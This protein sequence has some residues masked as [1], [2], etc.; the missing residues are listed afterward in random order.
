[1]ATNKYDMAYIDAMDGHTFENFVAAL[2][3][4]LG[5][6]NVEVTRGSGDQG[7]DVLADKEGVRYAVQCKCY[8]SDLGNTPVQEV[9]TGKVIYHCHVGVVV[10]NRYFTSG[11]KEAAKA[12]G[13]LLWDRT[14]L[15]ELV[16]Q[17]ESMAQSLSNEDALLRRG[18]MALEDEEWRK[19]DGFFEQ[20]INLN[21]ECGDAYLGKVL[22][23][24]QVSSL[25]ELRE[26]TIRLDTYKDFSR[27]LQFSSGNKL[28]VLR[29]VN[30]LLQKRW[31]EEECRRKD[32][33]ERQRKEEKA[34]IEVGQARQ[35]AER[36]RKEEEIQIAAEEKE[37]WIA[38][39]APF[40]KLL[41][42]RS[43]L[44][45]GEN[46]TVG[47]KADGIMITTGFCQEFNWKDIEAVAIGAFYTVGLKTDGTVVRVRTNGIKTKSFNKYD[48]DTQKDVSGWTSIIAIA[49]G[50]DHVAG[51]KSD[52]TVVAV[53]SNLYCQC[54]VSS[55]KNILAVATGWNYTVGLNF[56]GTIVIEGTLLGRKNA[57][58]WTSIVAIA[59][60]SHHA[61]GL[62]SDGTVVAVGNNKSGECNVSDWKD[63]VAVA[64]GGDHTVGLK[65]DGTVLAVGYN[66]NGECDVSSWKDIVA[67]AAGYS[68]TV[69]LKA[70]GTV[71]AVGYN[72]N[73]Q[74]NVSDWK[75][76]NS[77]ETLEQG[78]AD[79]KARVEEQQRQEK[80]HKQ[81]EEERQQQ[82]AIKQ[83]RVILEQEKSS[84]QTEFASLR[85]LFTGKKRREIEAKL[86]EIERRLSNL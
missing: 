16:I 41:Q 72:G 58:S 85:G 73:G 60:G 67:I 34:W 46:H 31:Q 29:E 61:V 48:F 62:K 83:R 27:A 55:W 43:P 1:M 21:A 80:E 56:D 40:R 11:A 7:V 77:I 13:V 38:R 24:V 39:M 6:Q 69:G 45:A 86:R 32:E 22:T 8:S 36:R 19:A 2:L 81:Q 82:E 9:N 79:A 4:K 17:A 30:E 65:T 3:R 49:T 57:S 47:I 51:L 76:F 70:D 25:E 37:R 5:Y 14:K 68:H 20:A 50:F 78:Q 15:Q 23:A 52:G 35:E 75:L 74:C 54:D 44:F 28:Q 18:F 10:T 64:A 33:I 26:K 42:K 59:A 71:L 66:G 53:G 63:I 84:L 12:T